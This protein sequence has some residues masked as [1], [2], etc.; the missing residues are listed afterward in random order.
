MHSNKTNKFYLAEALVGLDVVDKL[1][2][3]ATPDDPANDGFASDAG[4]VD[5][6]WFNIGRPGFSSENKS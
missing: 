5:V 2:P 3:R 6:P 4:G 1:L